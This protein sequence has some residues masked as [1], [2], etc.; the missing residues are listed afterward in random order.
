MVDVTAVVDVDVLVLDVVELDVDVLVLDVLV[1]DVDVEVESGSVVDVVVVDV[2]VVVG[3]GKVVDVVVVVGRDGG[4]GSDGTEMSPSSGN[5]SWEQ[6]IGTPVSPSTKL[7]YSSWHPVRVM[8]E[9]ASPNRTAVLLR[10]LSPMATA[11]PSSASRRWFRRG[12]YR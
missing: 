12:L 4:G 10:A 1:V 2:D 5:C 7:Q 8:L 6:S 9:R 3:S 11:L